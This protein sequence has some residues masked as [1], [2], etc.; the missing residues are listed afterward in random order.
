MKT[1]QKDGDQNTSTRPRRAIKKTK[2]FYEDFEETPTPQGKRKRPAEGGQTPAT[3]VKK[4]Q[5]AILFVGAIYRYVDVSHEKLWI[6]LP[7]LYVLD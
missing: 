2:K 1:E 7:L 4:V 3:K 6:L 5:Y